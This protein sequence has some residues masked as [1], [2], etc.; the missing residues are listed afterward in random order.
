MSFIDQPAA[1]PSSIPYINDNYLADEQTIVRELAARADTGESARG[2]ILD[3]AAQLVRAV[4]KNTSNDGGIEAFLQ[5]Y[6]LSSDEGVLLMCVAEALLRIPDADTADRLIADKITA[7]K[8]QDHVGTSDSLFVNASTWGLMLTGK[9]LTMDDMATGNPTRLLGKLVSRAGEPVVRTAMRQAMKIMGHQFVMGRNIGEALKRAMRSTDLPYRYSFDMLGESALTAEDA[10]RYLENYHEGIKSIANGPQVDA[11]DV[12]S[13]PGIS[14]KLSALH[15]RYE[16]SHEDRV[17]AELVPAVL[18]LAK[19]AKEVGIGLTI[20]SEEAHRLE[21]WLGIFERIYRDPALDGWEGFGVALQ[22]YQRR[23]NDALRFL[24]ELA[25]DVGRRIPVRL[26]KGA[27]WD[28]EVKWAQ[29]QGLSSYPVFT[30]KSH[31]DISY[32]AAARAALDAGDKIYAQFATHN[33]H[34]LASILHFAGSRRDYEFQRLHGMGEELYA[35]VVDP[36]KHDRPCRVYAPVGNHEDLLPYLVRR[37]LENGSNTSFVNKI[38]DESIDVMDIVADPLELAARHDYA[39]HDRIPTPGDIFQPERDNSHGVNLPDRSVSR[40][41][42]ADLEAASMKPI[43]AKPIIG[44]KEMN[45]KESP[46]VNPANTSEVIGMCHQANEEQVDRAI[47]LSVAAQPAW[48]R[49][50]GEERST[51][52]N[53]AADLFEK[54]SDELLRLCVMEGGRSIPDSISELREAVDFMRYYGAQA[55]K[56]YGEPIVLPGPTGERNT[57][58]MR[59]RGVFIAISPWNFPLAIFT[60]Q[61]TAALAAGNAVLAKPAA[62]TPLVAYRAVQLLHEAGVSPDVLHFIP[63][64]GR[65]VG[66]RAV[67]DPRVAGVVFTGSTEVAQTINQ[68][69]AHRD[70]PIGVL[71]AETGGQNA[72]FVDSSA[73]PE[74][75]VHDAIFSAFNSAGQRCSALR[76]LCVQEEIE[77]RTLDLLK[78]YMDEL[79]IGDPRHLSTDVG[80]VIDDPSRVTLGAHVER[81]AQ[82]QTLVH[83]CALP[84]ETSIGTYFAPTLV[85]IDDI[86]ALKREEFGPVLH[87]LKFKSRHLDKMVAAVNATGFG[88]TMGIHSRIDSRIAGLAADCGAGNLYVNRN[89]IGAVVGVQPFGGRGLSGTGPKAGGPNYVQRFGTEFTLSNNISAVG[90]NASLLT[91]GSD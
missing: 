14:V 89:M 7:A 49:L 22:T 70:G 72:M 86:S 90:G 36:A 62:P 28:S 19:H 30:R 53:R 23:G 51:I 9:I 64:S 83:R 91:L 29:E 38:A 50:G 78:G 54:H 26:V 43:T 46:S 27:Y 76:L 82:E 81:M 55:R 58:S 40:Q 34:T 5:Q 11:P 35:E 12:F 88:L 47:D 39:A 18:E 48:N 45:G 73:L 80:P 87:V 75:V 13:A 41:L 33:A 31:S 67:A 42:L 8:W 25:A 20:D 17:M 16:Y 52:L 60:G 68:T 6:D 63:G 2:K 24:I 10:L 1:Q 4:R 21:M 32:L 15:P 66:E 37:L 84:A 77:P 57:Y 44:G 74:Q 3:T 61:V 71:I 56:H 69:L 79:V 85:E 65:L 59:G